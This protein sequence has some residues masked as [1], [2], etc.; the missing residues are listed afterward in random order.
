MKNYS[1]AVVGAS[2]AVGE[3]I[4]R[5]LEEEKFPIAHFIPLASSASAGQFIEAFGKGWEIL[6]LT[7]QIFEQHKIDLVFF[8]CRIECECGVCSNCRAIWCCCD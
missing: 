1:V 4:I 6:E 8:F 5:I 3:E 7:P 2:G